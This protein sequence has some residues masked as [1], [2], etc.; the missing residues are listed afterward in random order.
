MTG[1]QIMM[2]VYVT[3]G[4]EMMEKCNLCVMF[5]FETMYIVFAM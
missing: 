2:S 1:N 5:L 3:G 4:A